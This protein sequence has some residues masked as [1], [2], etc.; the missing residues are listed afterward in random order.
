[1]AQL[2]GR[3]YQHATHDVTFSGPTGSY[4]FTSLRSFKYE[5]GASVE[6]IKDQAGIN[7]GW[8]RKDEDTGSPSIKLLLSEWKAFLVWARLQHPGKT[9]A[10]MQF[11]GTVTRGDDASNYLTD[12]LEG[13][14]VEKDMRE[15]SSDQNAHEIEVPLKILHVHHDGGDFI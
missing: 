8:V 5:T 12:K 11:D 6:F 10:Q 4:T 13:I 7:R 2:T 9:V 3:E 1:M 14:F 15:S